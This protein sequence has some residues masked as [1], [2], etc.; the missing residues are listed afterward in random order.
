MRNLRNTHSTAVTARKGLHSRTKHKAHFIMLV[1]F[2]K[3]T[4]VEAFDYFF[5]GAL[6]AF[7]IFFCKT[8][9][10]L[11]SQTYYIKHF[12]LLTDTSKPKSEDISHSIVII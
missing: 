5:I 7:L 10:I 11:N 9:C 12:Q 6:Y 4:M 1:R 8:K 3:R 2:L